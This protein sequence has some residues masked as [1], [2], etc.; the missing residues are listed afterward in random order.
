MPV[1][2]LKTMARYLCCWCFCV[3]MD[4]INEHTTWC[5]V[6]IPKNAWS[7][8]KNAAIWD[9][10]RLHVVFRLI[11]ITKLYIHAGNPPPCV[12]IPLFEMVHCLEAKNFALCTWYIPLWNAI[13]DMQ[14]QSLVNIFF[15][16]LSNFSLLALRN[17]T[18]EARLKTSM[19]KRIHIAVNIPKFN[20]VGGCDGSICVHRNIV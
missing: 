7:F 1:N 5:C 8:Q 20:L 3:S 19:E 13:W 15:Q 16:R 11:K 4:K 6:T 10:V 17:T 18:C 2:W 9:Y 12:G 14:S